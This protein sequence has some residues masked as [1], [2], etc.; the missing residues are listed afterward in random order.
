M[1]RTSSSVFGV[2]AVEADGDRL[3]VNV[4][5]APSDLAR[6]ERRHRWREA[7]RHPAHPRVLGEGEEV[8][9]HEGIAASED[10]DRRARREGRDVVEEAHA[11]G[12]R[13]LSGERLQDGFGA[14]VATG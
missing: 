12:G 2:R 1:P 7:E 3:R 11:V 13:E 4:A 5:Q 10:D 14:A 8:G 6:E 9:T